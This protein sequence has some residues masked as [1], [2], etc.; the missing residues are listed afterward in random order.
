MKIEHIAVY[1]RDL[2]KT[3][4]FYQKYFNAKSNDG[5]HNKNTGFRS[6]FLSFDDG[7]RIELMNFSELEEK[8]KNDRRTGLIH[9][10]FSVGSA[11]NVTSLT[12]QIEADGYTVTSRP[13]TTGDG[14]FE[15]CVAD[16]EGNLVEITV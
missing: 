8:S 12:A 4:E 1:V 13:R 11:E 16:P 2:E 3:R 6:Y 9:I 15:S 10:A 7:T 5:Y 14:Y